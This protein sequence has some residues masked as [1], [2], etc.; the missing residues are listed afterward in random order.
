LLLRR[1]VRLLRGAVRLLP[2][3]MHFMLFLSRDPR[4]L[5]NSIRNPVGRRMLSVG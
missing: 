5:P 1:A 3:G 4:Q 2:I